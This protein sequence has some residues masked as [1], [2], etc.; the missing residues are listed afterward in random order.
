MRK[1]H[2]DFIRNSANKSGGTRSNS[3]HHFSDNACF[4]MSGVVPIFLASIACIPIVFMAI[5][6]GGIGEVIAMTATEVKA[7]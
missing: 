3:G 5:L 2:I 1:P 7:T 6:A 4:I